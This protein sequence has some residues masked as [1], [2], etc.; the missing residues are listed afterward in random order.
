MM[1][2]PRRKK[3]F[4]G[5][6]R[7]W[8]PELTATAAAHPDPASTIYVYSSSRPAARGTNQGEAVALRDQ[9]YL[10]LAHAGKVHL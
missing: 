4:P 1:K 8:R 9:G 10:L 5:D 6:V 7:V 2:D 3:T